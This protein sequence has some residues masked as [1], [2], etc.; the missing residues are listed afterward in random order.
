VVNIRDKNQLKAVKGT[1]QL[2]AV[3]LGPGKLNEMRLQQA[4]GGNKSDNPDKGNLD[5]RKQNLPP[6]F[7]KLISISSI[8]Q[9]LGFKAKYLNYKKTNITMFVFF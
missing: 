1:G 2:R 6:R 5:C 8:P 4:Y 9:K 3:K 7:K